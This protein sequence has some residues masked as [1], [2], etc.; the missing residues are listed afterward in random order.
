M[1]NINKEKIKTPID[2]PSSKAKLKSL[3]ELAENIINTVREPLLILDE[4]LR[5]VKASRSFYDFFNV[6]SEETI[7][8][9][10][11]D[12]GNRQR[13]ILRL[14]ELLETILPEK[15]TLANYE[16]EYDFSG[17]DKRIMLLNARQ[18]E[19][20][21]GKEKIILLAFED[22]TE[23]KH[24]EE[25]LTEKN[26]ITNEYLDIL[27]N[28]TNVP[29]IIWDASRV[30]TRINHAF[31][32]LCGYNWSELINKKIDIF[33][34]KDQVDATFEL[35]RNALLNEK[36]EVLE[37]NILTKDSEIRTVLWNSANIFDKHGKNIIATI[38][39]DITKRKRTEEA[40]T[41]LE[42]R[43]RRLFESAKDGIL[44]LDA[45][46]GKIIDVNPFLIGL[47]G[48]SKEKFV[49]KSIWEIGFFKD[50]ATNE[51]KFFELQKKEYVRYEN[52][53]LETADGRK[54]N[55]EFVSSVYFVN[56]RKVIQCNIRDITERKLAEQTLRNERSLFRVLIDNIPDS[57]YSKDLRCRKTVANLAEIRNLGANSEAEVLG[58]ND[59][60]FYPKELAD[61]FYADDQIVLKTDTPVLNKEEF[62]FNAKGQKRWLLT[63]KIPLKDDKNRIIG[64]VGIGRD[65]TKHKQAEN[66][67]RNLSRAVEQ[68]PTSIIITNLLGEIEYANP[69]TLEITG[70]QLDELVG[71]NPRIFNSGETPP[72]E[73]EIL[74]NTISSGK[75]WSGEFHNKK[76]NGELYWESAS[77]SPIINE[78]GETEHYLA[79]KEDVT[80]KKRILTE[81]ISAKE[82][83]EESDKL[84]SEFLTQ[85][86]HEIRTPLN[87]IIGNVEY[88][89]EFFGDKKDPDSSDC[90][91]GI[92]L[93][94][95]RIIRTVDLILNA[96]ELQTNSY[97]PRFLEIDLNSGILTK[98]F[99]EHQRSARQKGLDIMFTCKEKNTKIIADEYSV[100]QIFANLIDNAVKFTKKGKVEILLDRNKMGN[101]FVEIKD[102]G[103]GM[104]KKFLPNIFAPFVQ[105]EQGYTRGFDGNGLGLA[106][107]KNYCNINNAIIEVESEKNVG[108]TFRIIFDKKTQRRNIE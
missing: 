15:T 81:L 39:Q 102:T 63:S 42:T 44:L 25:S 104:S 70:Y 67:L 86:S 78:K 108:S 7:G 36:L 77:I 49:E 29:I 65:I 28:N 9:L 6:T 62:L 35:I 40:L 10:I 68:S 11:Y 80:E 16:V 32:K 31:E 22:I 98:L 53:P 30:I 50:I 4:E 94:S 12:L 27:F 91:D 3:D 58:K 24:A 99:Q 69:K 45:E 46:T 60:D 1:I 96:A 79:V 20:A 82:K 74:W 33:F 101:I 89:K 105:E 103:I 41:V 88:I 93:A 75:E 64:L 76:K 26:R 72:G 66:K 14:K 8:K 85:I 37:T 59:F 106:L 43:Y 107:V 23:R 73:Y 52:L 13:D 97:E 100:I 34:P 2:P 55:V 48:Y 18:V 54:I 51:N 47:L 56:Y 92:N 87:A 17:K 83:A 57:I 84:K 71:K 90:F 19:R 5:V 61:G 38:A 95:R 21:L